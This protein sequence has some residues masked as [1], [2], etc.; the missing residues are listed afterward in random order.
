MIDHEQLKQAIRDK[1]VR[2]RAHSAQML[3]M[4]NIAREDIYSTILNGEIIE[5]Y[6]C[7]KPFPSA[8]FL[9][10]ISHRPIHVVASYDPSDEK[11]FIITAYEPGLEHFEPGFK[12][13][14]ET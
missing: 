8:L 6:S 4:R 3:I 2:F 11:I 7:D 13:R 14:R 9:G 10:W 12:I 1:R 5:D